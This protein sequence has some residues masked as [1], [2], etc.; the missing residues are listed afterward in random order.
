MMLEITFCFYLR[1]YAKKIYS[2]SHSTVKLAKR[3]EQKTEDLLNEVQTCESCQ[4]RKPSEKLLSR[5]SRRQFIIKF[6]ECSFCTSEFQ[7]IAL[8]AAN[9]VERLRKDNDRHL[10]EIS[11]NNRC[12]DYKRGACHKLEVW[13]PNDRRRVLDWFV[14]TN[15]GDDS[16]TIISAK[17]TSSTLVIDKIRFP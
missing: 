3:R 9:T 8:S 5:D 11:V 1:P 14:Q 6:L 4:K 10:P 13:L 15:D 7:R 2:M 12:F 17:I 16:R